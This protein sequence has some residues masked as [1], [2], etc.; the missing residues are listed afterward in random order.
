MREIGVIRKQFS[1]NVE[2]A[3]TYVGEARVQLGI[4]KNLMER[5]GLQQLTR[6]T[7]LPDGTVIICSSVQGQDTIS[8]TVG[9]AA[10][11]AAAKR[12]TEKVPAIEYLTAFH[13]GGIGAPRLC[14]P[15][16]IVILNQ[17]PGIVSATLNLVE[18]SSTDGGNSATGYTLFWT[19]TGTITV[20]GVV[21]G[22]TSGSAQVHY[23]PSGDPHPRATGSVSSW[24]GGSPFGGG[25]AAVAPMPS[26]PVWEAF[27]GSTYWGGTSPDLNYAW[28]P[29]QS[30]GSWT[31][32]SPTKESF[33]PAAGVY[34]IRVYSGQGVLL[35][36][37]PYEVD[38]LGNRRGYALSTDWSGNAW[39]DLYTDP[40]FGAGS[41]GGTPVLSGQLSFTIP[42]DVCPAGTS[43]AT[44][45]RERARLKACS[46]TVL[47]SLAAGA[48]TYVAG[49]GRNFLM[50]SANTYM[51]TPMSI[52]VVDTFGGG[53]DDSTD[54]KTVTLTYSYT[55]ANGVIQT[56][57]QTINGTART[58]VTH[59]ADSTGAAGMVSYTTT[60]YTDWLPTSATG[61]T[62]TAM[63]STFL[64]DNE[65]GLLQMQNGAVTTGATYFK[66]TF[67]AY[68]GNYH[69][70]LPVS[71]DTRAIGYPD[72]YR[73]YRARI[74]RKYEVG[75]GNKDVLDSVPFDG[76][77]ITVIPLSVYHSDYGD[78]GLF[79]NYSDLIGANVP[80]VSTRTTVL[81]D[82]VYS[83]ATG[84]WTLAGSRAKEVIITGLGSY[85]GNLN[86]AV[87]TTAVAS[88]VWPDV[89]DQYKLQALQLKT[90]FCDPPIN[91]TPLGYPE[92][93][94]AQLQGV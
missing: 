11:E 42:D 79:P 72:I 9:V 16:G 57:S 2:S 55:D 4:L 81:Y 8:I 46:D 15:I 89:A 10:E 14:Q 26:S 23:D 12:T 66:N 3:K 78:L 19:Q 50:I 47:A 1:G 5:G 17:P 48:A 44:L 92:T 88:G 65:D 34:E 90:G 36:S 82:F 38:D 69:P 43:A 59:C 24:V 93:L 68:G 40:H 77:V 7:V 87:R 33:V 70:P 76:E 84:T 52:A 62:G 85:T 49:L 73:R 22:S 39:V 71:A 63:D 86:F 6:K 51:Q 61:D 37:T 94:Y 80:K 31:A 18:S 64:L 28:A 60:T 67:D 25:V 54:T 32:V 53:G 41:T 30:S 27:S 75:L 58:A 83:Y 35:A 13:G 45:A 56:D 21:R 29:S 20:D 91:S 74:A